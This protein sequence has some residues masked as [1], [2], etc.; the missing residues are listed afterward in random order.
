MVSNKS[1]S[2]IFCLKVVNRLKNKSWLQTKTEGKTL[3]IRGKQRNNRTL[4][5]NIKKRQCNIQ[6]IE[7]LDNN[8][9]ITDLVQDILKTNDV[10]SEI[11]E[12]KP[13]KKYR[14]YGKRWKSSLKQ[15]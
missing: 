12:S 2:I 7:L 15:T 10:S 4:M 5:F 8:C 14:T 6:G 11:V 3:T 1:N 9:Y 13:I